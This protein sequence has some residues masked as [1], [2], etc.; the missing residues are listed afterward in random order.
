MVTSEINP[1]GLT[2]FD[3][4]HLPGQP[5]REALL[6]ALNAW[7][8]VFDQTDAGADEEDRPLSGFAAWAHEVHNLAASLAFADA[9]HHECPSKPGVFNTDLYFPLRA[10]VDEANG[11]VNAYYRCA[12]GETWFC[13]YSLSQGIG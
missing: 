4:S 1:R 12:C 10:D 9:T 11:S 3:H 8:H 7:A 13:S 2:S 6:R 5:E